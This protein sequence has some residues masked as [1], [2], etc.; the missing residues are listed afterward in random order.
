MKSLIALSLSLLV[1]A[2]AFAQDDGRRAARNA[3]E[4][5]VREIER[6]MYMRA[7]AG[8][9]QYIGSY[10]GILRPVVALD[11]AVG[12][13]FIDQE[14]MSVAWE[15]VFN[16]SLQNGPK[17]DQLSSLPPNLYI[18]GDVHT[19]AGAAYIE[20]S[21]YLTRRFGLGLKAGGGIMMLPVLMDYAIYQEDIVGG[22]WGGLP[23]SAHGGPLPLAGGGPTIEYYTKLS[24]F[25]IGADVMVNYVIGLDLGLSPTGYL[26]Y[27]F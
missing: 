24:H 22:Q 1:A 21:T 9:T 5:L 15:V 11:L 20:A 27:T 17:V 23:S 26:K 2:P 13:D 4:D 6:G 18:Q 16:Q 7:G 10:N 19:F 12:Q 14:R 3:D 8:S 25:S